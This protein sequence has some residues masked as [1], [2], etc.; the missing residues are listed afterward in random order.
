MSSWLYDISMFWSML[1][2]LAVNVPFLNVDSTA[3]VYEYVC[4][5]SFLPLCPIRVFGI[6]SHVCTQI[7][8]M[9]PSVLSPEQMG[10][11]SRTHIIRSKSD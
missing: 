5:M 7:Q 1:F 4:Y 2:L 6:V 3:E 11:N 8:I 9:L 10:G